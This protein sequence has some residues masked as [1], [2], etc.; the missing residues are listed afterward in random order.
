MPELLKRFHKQDSIYDN[1][2]KC[3]GDAITK[4][5]P[6]LVAK[7]MSKLSSMPPTIN[8]SEVTVRIQQKADGSE[9][10]TRFFKDKETGKVHI[11]ESD[12]R[13]ENEDFV[14]TVD[15]LNLGLVKM[16]VIMKLIK[17]KGPEKGFLHSYKD[18][19]IRFFPFIKGGFTIRLPT[20]M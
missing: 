4:L 8:N 14:E 7:I 5:G 3:G 11:F 1:F 2:H 10:W 18:M 13:I 15:P 20:F 16:E 12:Q 9:V 6:S 19:R 17:L